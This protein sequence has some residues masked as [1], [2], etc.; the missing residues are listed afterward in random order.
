[1]SELAHSEEGP[2]KPL[3]EAEVVV[4]I[5][6]AKMTEN[7]VHETGETLLQE[8]VGGP[9]KHCDLEIGNETPEPAMQRVY[10]RS[11]YRLH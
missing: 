2:G 11:S 5:T 7:H 10:D 3:R 4:Q 9:H 6:V 1:M 8:P